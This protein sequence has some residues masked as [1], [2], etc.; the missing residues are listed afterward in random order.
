M[1]PIIWLDFW[2]GLK[3]EA[4]VRLSFF[5]N[6]F[7]NK[8]M[9]KGINKIWEPV[10]FTVYLSF[11][12]WKL[13][14][15]LIWE[16]GL[17]LVAGLIIGGWLFD[18][19]EIICWLSRLIFLYFLAYKSWRS[20]GASPMIAAISGSLAGAAIGFLAALSRFVEG[21][22]VWKFFNLVT[23]TTLVTVV[24]CLVAVLVIYAL[25]FKKNY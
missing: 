5:S 17:R 11:L 2:F 10:D 16:I 20:F 1:L 13:A 12:Q 18:N 19:L 6:L 21:F 24:G 22:K 23:E 15:Y 4:L 14:A 3:F 7:Y 9:S 8:S 25:S